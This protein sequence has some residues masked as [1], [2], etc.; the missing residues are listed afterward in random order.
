[1]PICTIN[2][3]ENDAGARS[4]TCH[5]CRASMHRWEKRRPAE[6]LDRSHKL[7]LYRSRMAQ[8][9]VV[10]DDEVRMRPREELEKA[11]VMFFSRAAKK[12][13]KAKARVIQIQTAI[14]Q[15]KRRA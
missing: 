2:G 1:M 9:A 4:T 6:I 8:F 3:C 12:K 14:A 7:D 5:L 10:K 11:G 15:R 13:A